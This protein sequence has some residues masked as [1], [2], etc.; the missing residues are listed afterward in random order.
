MKYQ[1]VSDN[2]VYPEI[3][4]E[5]HIFGYTPFTGTPLREDGDWRDYLPP[6]EDQNKRGVESSA[7]YIEAQQHTIATIEEESL[8]EID[9]NYSARFNALLSGGTPQGGDPLKGADSIRNDG[10]IPDSAM[11]FG[12]NITSF[13]EFHSWKGVVKSILIKTGQNYLTKK[14]INY[15]IVFKREESI[16]AKYAKIRQALKYSPLPVSVC[17]WFQERDLYVK[18]KGMRDNHLVELVYVDAE[19]HPYIRDTY[20]PYQKKLEPFYDFDFGMVL[21]V[22]KRPDNEQIKLSVFDTLKQYGLLAFFA[23]F[24]DRFTRSIGIKK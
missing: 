13:D 24:L 9:N 7:C 3:K 20:P 23:D 12:D 10:L 21:T 17:G 4:P 18:P 22:A 14:K 1:R 19:G 5:L 11:P 8:E 6:E 2:F 16:D 15:Q